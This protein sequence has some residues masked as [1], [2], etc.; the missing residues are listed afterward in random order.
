MSQ[1]LLQC[2]ALAN[3]GWPAVSVHGLLKCLS[4]RYRAELLG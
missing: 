3:V 2:N 1:Y 4:K